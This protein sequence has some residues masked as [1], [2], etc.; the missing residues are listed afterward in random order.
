[1]YRIV[2][3]LGLV[4]TI[5]PVGYAALI[6]VPEQGSTISGIGILYGWKCEAGTL[7]ARFNDGEPVD[8]LYGSARGDTLDTCGDADNG[9]VLLVNYNNLGPGGHTAIVYDDG[10]EFDRVNFTVVTPGVEYLRDVTGS[11]TVALSNGQEVRVEW[12][13][14]TQ[15]FVATEFTPP[16]GSDSSLCTTKTATVYDSEY[17]SVA[18]PATWTVTNPCDGETLDIDITPLTSG[19]FF[20][21]FPRLEF[22]QDGVQ[23]DSSFF[24]WFDRKTFD[25]VCGDIL[26]GLMKKTTVQIES[27]SL[28]FSQPFKIYYDSQLIF[29]FP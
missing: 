27:V 22:V 29:E 18:D 19:G 6:E 9:W 28:N 13:E 4:L 1:M 3:V 16:P 8:I 24:D 12:S 15:G 14:E 2:A 17:R 23:F 25:G 20:A 11:G 5:S 10:V 26:S 7:T 21:C